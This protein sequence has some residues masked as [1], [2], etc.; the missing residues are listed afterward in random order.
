MDQVCEV[1]SLNCLRPGHGVPTAL[2]SG[3]K[4]VADR[5]GLRLGPITADDNLHAVGFYEQRGDV[6]ESCCIA[7]SMES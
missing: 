6:P 7:T 2:L 1:I 5:N 4:A 3:A